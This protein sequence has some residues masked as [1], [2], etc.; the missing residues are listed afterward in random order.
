[1]L[2]CATHQALSRIDE[3]EPRGLVALAWSY[4]HLAIESPHLFDAIAASAQQRENFFTEARQP[5][6]DDT[7]LHHAIYKMR[8]IQSYVHDAMYATRCTRCYRHHATPEVLND[9]I[10]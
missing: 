9:T 6:R 5:Q 3:F 7:I 2:Y 4:A 1:M 10:L 8:R